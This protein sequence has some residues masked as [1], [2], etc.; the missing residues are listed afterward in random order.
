MIEGS[1]HD[2]RGR[3]ISRTTRRKGMVR[4]TGLLPAGTCI[5]STLI[6]T[7]ATVTVFLQC[8]VVESCSIAS[9]LLDPLLRAVTVNV[10]YDGWIMEH[11]R[12]CLVQTSVAV[13]DQ[14]KT[15]RSTISVAGADGG[16]DAASDD[17]DD[18]E[19]WR[20]PHSHGSS[21]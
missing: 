9:Y 2:L 20:L 14:R 6:I 21:L 13:G 18:S 1:L 5:P 15:G 7:I 4:N 17:M 3:Q 11:R 16:D 8:T 19:H 12:W 10:L